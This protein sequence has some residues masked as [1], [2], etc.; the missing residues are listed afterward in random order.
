[1]KSTL[2]SLPRPALSSMSQPPLSQVELAIEA[3]MAPD[4][5]R[6]R[7]RWQSLAAAAHR[8]QWQAERWERLQEEIAQSAA[9]RAARLTNLPPITYDESLPIHARRQEIAAA[10]RNHPVV[11]VCGE[12]GSG[13]STQLPKICLEIGRGVDGVIGHTQPRRLAARTISSRLAQELRS[14]LGQDVGFKIRFTDRTRPETY[15]KLMTDGILLAETPT[16]RFLN[17]YDTIILDEAHERSLNIDFL[18]GYLRRLLPKRP[19]L[20]CIITSATIDAARFRDHFVSVTGETPVI[21][22]SG[23]AYPVEVHYRPPEAAPEEPEPE[24]TEQVAAAVAELDRQQ[25]GDILV[26]LP[27]ERDIRETA[28]ELGRRFRK[29]GDPM[30]ILP[31]YARLPTKEQNRVFEAHTQRRVV[32][33]T[34]VAESSLTVPGIRA[35]IDTGTARISRYSPRSKVQRL[36]I[37]AISRASADQRKGRC[38]RIGP[39]ICIRLY[40]EED[41]LGREHYTTPEIRRTNLASVILQTLALKL[42]AIEDFPFLDPPRADAIR[43]GYKTLFELGAIDHHRALTPLG[44]ELARLPVDPRIGRM[45]LAADERNC[46]EEVLI[47]AAGLELHDPRERPI[48]KAEAAD[49]CHRQFADERSDFLGI[50]KLWDFYHHLKQTLSRNQLKRACRQNFLSYSRLREW[51]DIYR[52]LRRLVEESGRKLHPRRD[53]YDTIHQALLC[54]L[55]SGIAYRS[56]AYEYTGAGDNRLHIWPGSALFAQRPKWITAAELVETSRRYGRIVAR[57]NP[58]WIEPLAEHLVNRT[59]DEPHWDSR[60]GSAM[61]FERVSLFGLPIVP[62]RRVPLGPVEPETARQL[63]IQHG[64]V[65][66]DVS[67]KPAFLERNESL[68]RAIEQLAARQRRTDWIISQQTLYEFYD[69]RLP[70]DVIDMRRLTHWLRQTAGDP[71][72]LDMRREDLLAE[73]ATEESS[74]QYPDVLAIDKTRFPLEYRFA[75]GDMQDGI[76]MTVPHTAINQISHAEIDWLVPGHLEEK[77]TAL[78]RALPKAIRRSLVPAPDTARKVV[79]ELAFGQGPF[80]PTLARALERISGER[81]PVDA[82]QLDRL[83]SHLVMK[84]RV[85][86][87]RGKTLGVDQSLERLRDQFATPPAGALGQLEDASWNRPATRQ[88]DFGNLPAEIL[89]TRGGLRVPA[90]PAVLDREDGVVVRLVDTADRA[91]RESRAGI[92]RLFYFSQRKALQAHVAWLPRLRETKLLAATVPGIQPLEDHLALLLADRAFLADQELPRTEAEYQ[93]R[94][95]EAATRAGGAVQEITPLVHPLFEALHAARLALE[96]LPAARWPQTAQDVQRQIDA[97]IRPGFLTDTPW[98]WLCHFPRYFRAI[99]HRLD[100]LQHG[101]HARDQ[102]ALQQLAPW[103]TAYEQRAAQHQQ[104]GAFDERLV[105]YRWML[106]ELRVSLFAQHLGTSMP[107]SVQRLEKQWAEIS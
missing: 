8:G 34:N 93:Q 85:V 74:A 79:P 57:I 41:Y 53:E 20:R 55:L 81:I 38:G 78:I 73:S 68:L 58:D 103:T 84:I 47:I 27:T 90:Y 46:L 33:A 54:G 5:Y 77:V 72:T 49:E 70:A 16:D 48:D 100:K 7:M 80:L 37:E 52:Q 63:L 82:F 18:L 104:R 6:L 4:R 83:P 56:D 21:E 102:Q 98:M 45:I 51:A 42:G 99:V 13:K 32:L 66:G 11:I 107:V 62:R 10:I 75:P 14:P 36:P 31:L 43:D 12:T 29:R 40:G 2:E 30:E 35:V 28:A 22:V 50:L 9:R 87:E 96:K 101:G 94:L 105:V 3:A 88:W 23:R 15:I 86:D 67:K 17:Q 89:I 71:R 26:F 92:R 97:L 61:V 25:V 95:Q 64:L 44:R 91:R 69:R 60:S 24:V 1:M 39:G 76:T 19:E 65:E 106:E 59:Y